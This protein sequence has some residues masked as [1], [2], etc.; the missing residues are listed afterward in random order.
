[1]QIRYFATYREFTGR[2]TEEVSAP[3]TVLALLHQ[4]SEVYGAGLRKW[5]LS[6]DGTAKGENSIVMVNGRHIEHLNGVD[7]VLTEDDVV[8]LFPTVAGG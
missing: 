5:L 3:G 2:L 4:L 8:S 6:Q 1:M 7:T